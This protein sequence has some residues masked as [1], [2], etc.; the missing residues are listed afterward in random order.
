MTL[1]EQVALITGARGIGG[2]SAKLLAARGANVVVAY[3]QNEDAAT[4]LVAEITAAGG[5]ATAFQCD[6][7]A[8][9][10]V[11]AL[12]VEIQK[13]WGRLDI[14]VSNAGGGWLEKPLAEIGWQEYIDVV[15]SEL[16]AAFDLTKA[17]LPMMKAQQ[18]GRLIYMASN[19][20]NHVLPETVASSC[21]KAALVA[22]MRNVAVEVGPFGI[23]ANAILPALVMTE[24]TAYMPQVAQ[25]A[26]IAR[27]PLRRIATP[28]EIAGVVA[29]FASADS[30]F[31]T[32]ASLV[33]DGGIALHAA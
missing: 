27:T 19:L 2:A 6:V 31:V 18:A 8:R 7:L 12:V 10:Q 3:R 33:V 9:E 4:A 24:S 25:Q 28:A 23:T 15:D 32:G 29:F 14:L 20:A 21:A 5:K 30:R 1:S 22:L 17:I 13:R 11:D 26:I 16:K